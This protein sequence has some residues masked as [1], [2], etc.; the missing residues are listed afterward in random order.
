MPLFEY[1][2]MDCGELSEILVLSEDDRIDCSKCGSNSLKKMISAHASFS[3]V[4]ANSVP[5]QG[6][7]ACCGSTPASAGCAG[8]GSCCG[9]NVH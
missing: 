2:C 5:G 7:T 1:L 8:P 4:S 9:K 3:G 6:D